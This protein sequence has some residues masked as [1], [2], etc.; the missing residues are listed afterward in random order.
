MI[1]NKAPHK[2]KNGRRKTYA[3]SEYQTYKKK[4]CGYYFA[5][6]DY[7]IMKPLL[8]YKYDRDEMNR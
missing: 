8:I 5:K 3:L 7:E 6:L 2:D 4:D 1:E